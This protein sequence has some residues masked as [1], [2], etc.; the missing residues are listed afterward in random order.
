MWTE[1]DKNDQD[2]LVDRWLLDQIKPDTWDKIVQVDS[3]LKERTLLAFVREDLPLG[4]L[5]KLLQFRTS[6]QVKSFTLWYDHPSLHI[7]V[8]QKR[9]KKNGIILP[10]FF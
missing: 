7:L 3:N 2:S 8:I 1:V 6:F 10:I 9:R 5:Q 4:I